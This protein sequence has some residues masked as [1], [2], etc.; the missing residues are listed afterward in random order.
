MDVAAPAS[1]LGL[2]RGVQMTA[3][4]G[5]ARIPS[6]SIP[7]PQHVSPQTLGFSEFNQYSLNLT[8]SHPALVNLTESH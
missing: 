8:K 6:G 7:I 5:A 2:G 4:P 3:G 1:G